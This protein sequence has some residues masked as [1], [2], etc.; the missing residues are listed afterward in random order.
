LNI[1]KESREYFENDSAHKFNKL[2]EMKSFLEIHKLS[3]C[4]KD[5]RHSNIPTTIKEGESVLKNLKKTQIST[6]I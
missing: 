2:S 4:I 6:S 1:I 5:E 3:Q